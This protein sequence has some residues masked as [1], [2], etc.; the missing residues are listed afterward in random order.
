[1]K[2]VMKKR[3]FLESANKKEDSSHIAEGKQID[4]NFFS[5][6]SWQYFSKALKINV[7]YP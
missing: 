2:L 1:M 5:M 7:K 3:W 6:V 4:N